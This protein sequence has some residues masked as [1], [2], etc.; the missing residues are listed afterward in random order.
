LQA[1]ELC[2]PLDL[3]LQALALVFS[4]VREVAFKRDWVFRARVPSQIPVSV[5][6]LTLLLIQ[7]THIELLASVELIEPVCRAW[8]ERLGALA[9]GLLVLLQLEPAFCLLALLS[10]DATRVPGCHIEG[11]HKGD[12]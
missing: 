9:K 1:R 8:L 3:H 11:H 5:E 6:G 12:E 4:S 2:L 10:A 7:R